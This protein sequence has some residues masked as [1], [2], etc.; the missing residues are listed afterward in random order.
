MMS[1]GVTVVICCHNS[2]ERLPQTLR[3]L[4]AQQVPSEIPWEVIVIDNASTDETARVALATWPLHMPIPL[5][6][7]H[8]PRLGLSYARTRGLDEATYQIVSFIDDDNWVGSEWLP[9]I[10][11]IM[12][13]HPDIGACGGCVEAKCEIEK[14]WWF[15]LHQ[16][17]Y[18]VGSQSNQEGDITWSRGYLWGAGLTIRKAAWE[19]IR[20]LGFR[21]LLEDRKGGMLQ[22]G[23]DI[24]LCLALRLVGW[25]LWYEPKLKMV[26]YI[27]AFRLS[28]KYLRRLV[29]S[30]GSGS[31][32]HRAYTQRTFR[33][34]KSWLQQYWLSQTSASVIKL[35]IN[36]TKLLLTSFHPCEWNATVLD[37]ESRIGEL[38]QLAR[39]PNEYKRNCRIVDKIFRQPQVSSTIT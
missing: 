26:H 7:V 18:A 4:A 8:E 2:V 19:Q 32:V 23:G 15:H 16:E 11:G 30:C 5:R 22:S 17:Y 28:W 36:C 39:G 33:D 20:S 14:P 25:K 12:S 1:M 13:G 6:I 38:Q 29:R 37:V 35:I 24:E 31:V 9:L 21:F 10:S 34:A 3:H 27:P